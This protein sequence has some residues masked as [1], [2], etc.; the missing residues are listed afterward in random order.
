MPGGIADSF[1]LIY[2]EVPR[3]LLIIESGKTFGEKKARSPILQGFGQV[4][5]VH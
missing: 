5:Y 2:P 1:V 4:F 3:I